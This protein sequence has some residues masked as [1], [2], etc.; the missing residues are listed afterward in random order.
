M[1]RKLIPRQIVRAPVSDLILLHQRR[2]RVRIDEF[3]P[4]TAA[5]LRSD[6]IQAGSIVFHTSLGVDGEP[7]PASSAAAADGAD[8][9]HELHF[10]AMVYRS[11]IAEARVPREVSD[12]FLIWIGTL[13]LSAT[14]FEQSD[15]GQ[16]ASKQAAG[17]AAVAG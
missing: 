12:S 16:A 14:T 15:A 9:T 13:G 7:R 2:T 11:G 6:A 4:G 10:C 8:A 1:G 5:Q 17:S 3:T